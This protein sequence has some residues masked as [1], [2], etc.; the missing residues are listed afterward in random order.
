[1]KNGKR[2]GERCVNL[3]ENLK[4]ALYEVRPK[5]CREFSPS[6][7]FCGVSHDDALRLI[8]EIEKATSPE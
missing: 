2:A 1:M 3:Q 6:P 7:E 4:C 8:A 5:V